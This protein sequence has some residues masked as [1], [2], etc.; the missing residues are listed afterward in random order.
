MN[1][2]FD[3]SVVIGTYNRSHLLAGNL[4]SLIAQNRTGLRY[5]LIVVDNNSTDNTR[6]VVTSFQDG[7]IPVRYFFEGRQGVSHARNT[8]IEQARSA[9]V[10][11]IDD[12]VRADP[13]WISTIRRTFDEHPE[14]GFIGGK[15]LPEWH[16]TP[17][18]WLTSPHWSPLAIQDHGDAKVVLDAAKRIGVIS[19]NLA[20]RRE[21]FERVGMFSINVQLVKRTIG[22]MEDHELID[23]LWRAGITG[24]YVPELV[25]QSPVDLERAKKSYH[26]RWHKGHGYYYA[27]LR[28]ESMEKAS[29]HL[30]GVP[31]HL[32]RQALRNCVGLT[33]KWL[34]RDE[35]NAFLCEVQL[36]FFWGFWLTRVRGR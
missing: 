5:E 22:S 19:A 11:F 13:E 14:V 10:A 4:E 30:F 26:R 3:V 9:I 8:G 1:D 36:W 7:D 27:V 6:D 28:E 23:R 17:P 2:E 34:R 29:W 20:V 12:D 21:L 18:G 16:A 35:E 33:R 32:Y 24:L 31:A 25:V 15:V